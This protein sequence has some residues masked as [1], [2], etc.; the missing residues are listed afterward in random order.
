MMK[1][2][3]E[4][5]PLIMWILVV[6]FL[7]TIV[8]SW[9]AG[10][11]KGRGP[12]PGVIAQV[13]SREILYEVFSKTLQDR[14]ASERAKSDS[15]EL[16]EDDITKMR[17]DVWNRLVRDALLDYAAK[18]NG[19]RIVDKEVAWAVRNS[20]PDN[21]MKS[22]YFQTDGKFDRSKWDA[23]LNDPQSEQTLVSLE[24]DYR[25]SIYHQKVL[26]QVL[27]ATFVTEDEIQRDFMDS[28]MRFS[29]LVTGY[30]VRDI[31]VDSNSFSEEDIRKYYFDHQEQF[32]RPEMRAVR[33]VTFPDTPTADD[34]AR[35]M[36]Q[37]QEVLDRL[38]NGED[39]AELAK[40]YSG[41][42]GSASKG[43]DLGYFPRGR[44]VG[45]F[46]D[47]AFS[48]PVGQVSEPVKTRFGVHILK[49]TDHKGKA[50][51]DTVRASHILFLWKASPE[52]E[53]TISEKARDFQDLATKIGFD[54]AA[55]RFNLEVSE[56][57]YFVRASGAIP[58]FGKLEPAVDFIFSESPKKVSY[59]YKTSKGYTVFQ[60]RGVQKEGE[61]DLADARP[62]IVAR[63][64]SAKKLELAAEKADTLRQKIGT[65]TN[66]GPTAE[67][68]G[69]RVDTLSNVLATGY[70]GPMKGN[71]YVGREIRDLKIGE[72]SPVLRTDQGAFLAVLTE[73]MP[74]D[75]TLFNSK[76]SDIGEKLAR[77]KQGEI[78][79]D[80]RS[81][82]EK[83]SSFRDNRYVFFTEY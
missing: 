68:E 74:F 62:A 25:K 32:W 65:G 49:V 71:E 72:L 22:E 27:A 1:E 16:K 24:K 76:K 21:V 13:G 3:R 56:S 55:A 45:E 38:K 67:R 19:I 70:L 61:Q 80:W 52:T 73:K 63:L 47:V 37:A 46:E 6:A 60:C 39:F 29:A 17:S 31:P 59:A 58:G 30:A 34:S 53:E 82:L 75:S 40:E 2:L 83:Q 35:I 15:V 11:F 8:V 43:G 48:T 9:G 69:L 81:M 78:Y 42:P 18:K 20:P 66:L 7:V 10:G 33:S 50:P 44:M 14:I 57:D 64:V 23:F 54:Q 51:D 79:T 26:D 36:E 4:N 77:T 5:M 28:Y 12:K 41:D